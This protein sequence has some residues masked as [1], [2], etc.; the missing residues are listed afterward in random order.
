MSIRLR[1]LIGLS[2]CVAVAAC[3]VPAPRQLTPVTAPLDVDA[4]SF[5]Y[6]HLNSLQPQSI[7]LGREMCGYYF[8]DASGRIFATAPVI[9]EATT[10]TMTIPEPGQ[11]VFASYHTQG[12]YLAGYDTEVPS[13]ADRRGDFGLGIDGY[14]STPGGNL[15]HLDYS[16]RSENRLCEGCLYADPMFP[17]R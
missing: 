10:C 2:A 6:S 14:I 15:W 5:A 7:A 12:A 4:A 11:R 3:N 16:S 8:T 9:G 1:P 17:G 13:T